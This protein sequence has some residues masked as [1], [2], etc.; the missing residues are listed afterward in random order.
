[1]S[2]YDLSRKVIDIAKSICEDKESH[3]FSRLCN[4]Q[5]R[6]YYDLNRVVDCRR[7]WEM[8]LHIREKVKV[9]PDQGDIAISLHNMGDLEAATGRYDE[10]LE[11]YKRAVN[12][13][14]TIGD[15]AALLL[16][17][18]YL[19]IGLC[20]ACSKNYSEARRFF[21]QAEQ[22]FVRTVGG[23]KYVMAK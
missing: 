16:G 6:N 18:T 2:D 4:I 3:R 9:E 8:A 21:G 10:A 22:L 23:F 5:G 19:G 1:M 7:N 15:G 12:I 11:Y 13:R 20:H 14:L 17:K